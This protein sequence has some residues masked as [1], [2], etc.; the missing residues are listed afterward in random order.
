MTVKEFI[1]KIF[2]LN[3][4]NWTI[5]I[6]FMIVIE[7]KCFVVEILHYCFFKFDAEGLNSV[8]Q[9]TAN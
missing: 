1:T 9:K 2:K 8:C 7:K 4:A 5:L 6:K 3:K